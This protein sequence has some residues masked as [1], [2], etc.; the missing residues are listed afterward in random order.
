MPDRASEYALMAADDDREAEAHTWA[1]A[2][3]LDVADE[4]VRFGRNVT[5]T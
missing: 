5:T 1:E 4:E 3:L 2:L